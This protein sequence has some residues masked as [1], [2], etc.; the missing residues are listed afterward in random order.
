VA[1]LSSVNDL[2]A[3]LWK[4][5][6]DFHSRADILTPVCLLFG[7]SIRAK[8]MIGAGGRDP[9][10]DAPNVFGERSSRQ[11]FDRNAEPAIEV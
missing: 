2:I 7:K 6:T 4:T 9:I 3:I 1:F 8:T 10:C 11:L 5:G